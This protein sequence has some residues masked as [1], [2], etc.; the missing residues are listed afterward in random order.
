MLV[1]VT[2][3]TTVA[4]VVVAFVVG[5]L[6][7][8]PLWRLRSRR[9]LR[10]L[11]D[12]RANAVAMAAERHALLAERAAHDERA[13][14]AEVRGREATEQAEAD[15]AAAIAALERAEAAEVEAALLAAALRGCERG[16]AAREEQIDALMAATGAQH[17][18]ILA[19]TRR[20]GPAAPGPGR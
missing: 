4:T 3:T 8:W 16:A 6:L 10:H 19:L 18:R 11:A 14:E 15:R 13:S 7:S 5:L 1:A 2:T 9:L 12:A 17:K 20:F